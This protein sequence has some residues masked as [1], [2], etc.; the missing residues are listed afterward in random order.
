MNAP[1]RKFLRAFHRPGGIARAK[2][3]A[4]ILSGVVSMLAINLT[5]RAQVFT[6]EAE[7]FPDEGGFDLL[8]I[9]CDPQLSVEGGW[10]LLSVDLC[11]GYDP[12]GGQGVGYRRS[13][14][15]FLGESEFFIQWRVETDADQSE[16]PWGGGAGIATGSIGP[17]NYT[18]FIT[19]D[20]VKTQSR[21]HAADHLR[22]HRARRSAHLPA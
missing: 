8:Q 6:Y 21:Q 9:F 18:F 5:A 1:C 16:I 15:E 3:A 17:V 2:R 20:L 14:D 11:E 13:L 12:P 4:L 22:R 7:T 10:F 19:R